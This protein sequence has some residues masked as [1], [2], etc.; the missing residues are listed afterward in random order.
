[1]HLLDDAVDDLL[2]ECTARPISRWLFPLGNDFLHIDNAKSS[3]FAGTVVDCDGRLAKVIE[4]GE[5]AAGIIGANRRLRTA[6]AVSK[7]TIGFSRDNDANN[8]AI[9]YMKS[10]WF[11]DDQSK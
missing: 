4:A 9:D 11:S 5:M 7:Q 6:S 2:A 10:R 8:Q 3:T 1:M